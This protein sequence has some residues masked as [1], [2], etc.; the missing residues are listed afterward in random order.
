MAKQSSTELHPF[1]L[2]FTTAQRA[3][4]EQAIER[5]G[6][7]LSLTDFIRSTVLAAANEILSRDNGSKS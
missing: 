4:I 3:R 1:L 2:R 7:G 5:Q 6:L